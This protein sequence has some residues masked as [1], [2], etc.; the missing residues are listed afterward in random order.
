[1]RRA[2]SQA[3]QDG[4]QGVPRPPEGTAAGHWVSEPQA[5]A[6]RY[7][8]HHAA[9]GVHCSSALCINLT[10]P[11]AE[12]PAQ[13]ERSTLLLPVPAMETP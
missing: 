6:E 4:F 1:M 5:T 3:N 12:T 7:L 8:C 9:N 2:R 13:L 10:S 11:K